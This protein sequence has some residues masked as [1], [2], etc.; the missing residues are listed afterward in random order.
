MNII[1]E[2]YRK[3]LM[4]LAGVDPT[5]IKE[6]S[7]L[8]FLK[9]D[10]KERIERKYDK[11]LKFYSK[12]NWSPDKEND[13]FV[14]NI[15]LKDAFKEGRL[16]SKE[17]WINFMLEQFNKLEQADPTENKQYLSW[18]INVYL[19]GN[20]LEEDIY[21]ANEALTSFT[22]NKEK[23]PVE[24]RNINYFSDLTTL[25]E[26]VAKYASN[27]EM[28]AS[29]KEKIIKLEG[30]E[31]VYDS[32]NWKIIIPKT[33]DAAC[34]YGKSTK[35][36]TASQ[37]SNRFDYYS[38]NGPLFI[39]INKQITNDRDV[40]KKYQFHF[41]SEQFMDTL[42][43]RINITDFFKK[44]TEL[45][46]FFKK[47]GKIDAGFEIEHMLVSKEE[48]L[49]LLKTLQNKIDL[50]KR[51]GFDFFKKFFIEIG[52]E[53]EFINII[54]NDKDF[55]KYIIEEDLY[56]DLFESYKDMNIITEGFNVLKSIPWL[57][58]WISNS[59]TKPETIQ[60]FIFKISEIFGKPA[61][62]FIKNLLE[63]GGVIWNKFLQPKNIKIAHYFNMLSS[64]HSLGDAGLKMAKKMLAD[65]DVLSELISKGV[66]KDTIDMLDKFY[67]MKNES[68]QSNIYLKNILS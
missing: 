52:A 63:R 60:S 40:F 16:I 33:K 17:L 9:N 14:K 48:G 46:D 44:N 56:D 51:K 3:K 10:F 42:D 65:K 5:M 45:K 53:K 43:R 27:E 67:K 68:Y 49:K 50:I 4:N 8:D 35:W 47:S 58:S 66:S 55:I 20:L 13:A 11:F 34:L 15:L 36:C 21:K 2:S 61:I 29:E 39:L 38:K 22:K 24:Q 6:S 30:A 54:L 26:V 64:R 25:F 32:P 37:D 18:L 31:Q 59:E 41:E 1:S 19:S 23:I 28:S 57:N 62:E 7:R 12:E